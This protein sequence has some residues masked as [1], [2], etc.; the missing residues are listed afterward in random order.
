MRDINLKVQSLKHI[1]SKQVILNDVDLNL[2]GA[3]AVTLLGP[4]GAG[5]STLLKSIAAHLYCQ[6]G[7]VSLN[8]INSGGSRL[9]YLSHIGYMPEVPLIIS[10]LTVLEQLKLMAN[11]KQIQDV[12]KSI[13]RVL[14]TC[15]LHQ[16]L[17]KRTSQLSLGY[18]QRLN[19]AQAIMNKP[20]LLIMDEP[21]NGLDPHLIIEFRNIIKQLKKDSLIIISTHY[22]AEAQTISDRV[23]I[24]QSGIMLDNIKL[25]QQ[26][27]SNDLEEIYMQ[28]TAPKERVI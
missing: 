23:L 18:K 7:A 5:K 13:S 25:N 6:S 20:L 26:A 11:I 4:N 15:E 17:D 16:V 27:E 2:Q 1:I 19:L 28:H 21:L 24:M 9:E 3:Q 14:E 12:E 22:L 8:E 10:E